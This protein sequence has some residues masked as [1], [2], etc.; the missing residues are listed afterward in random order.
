M[1]WN[2]PFAALSK[3]GSFSQ[4]LDLFINRLR[5]SCQEIGMEG[6]GMEG[7]GNEIVDFIS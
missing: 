2:K 6:I 3:F 7:I 4:R 1:I 5:S